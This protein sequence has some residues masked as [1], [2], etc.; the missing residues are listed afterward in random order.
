MFQS[1]EFK[2]HKNAHSILQYV[3]LFNQKQGP[4][5]KVP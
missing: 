4:R 3:A 5:P 1:E 2:K